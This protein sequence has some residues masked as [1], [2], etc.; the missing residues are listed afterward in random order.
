MSQSAVDTYLEIAIQFAK[1]SK[2]IGTSTFYSF[3]FTFLI[4]AI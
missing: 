4:Y 2:K 1:V 3:Y